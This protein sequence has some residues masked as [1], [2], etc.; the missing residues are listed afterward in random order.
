MTGTELKERIELVR[1]ITS[2]A[3]LED[4]LDRCLRRRPISEEQ[5][6]SLRRQL[7]DIGNRLDRK[8][9]R[10]EEIRNEE[11]FRLSALRPSEPRPLVTFFGIDYVEPPARAAAAAAR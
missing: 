6:A 9:V 4:K 7:D 1:D 11:L 2:L 10:L 5:I 3:C 8:I